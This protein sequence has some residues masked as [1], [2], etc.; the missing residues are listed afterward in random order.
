MPQFRRH[1]RFASWTLILCAACMS[2]WLAACAPGLSEFGTPALDTEA[3]ERALLEASDDDALMDKGRELF[4]AGRYDAAARRFG[5]LH[6]RRPRDLETT[7]RL[8]LA[9]WFA[10]RPGEAE[11][12]WRDFPAT[13]PQLARQLAR[14]AAALRILAH[15]LSA[16]RILEDHRRGELL[17]AEPHGIVLLPD[18]ARTEDERAALPGMPRALHALLLRALDRVAG[19]HPADRGL[20]LALRAEAGHDLF[21]TPDEALDLARVLGTGYAATVRAFVPEEAPDTLRTT[22]TLLPAEPL[23]VRRA[24]L[25]RE[26]RRAEAAWSSAEAE[27]RQL[28]VRRER[29]ANVLSYFNAKHRLNDLLARRK[30][31]A[32]SAARMN[33]EGNAAQA[34]KAMRRHAE[35]SR[36]LAETQT[37]I[38]DYERTMVLGVEG[39]WRF[40]PEAYRELA[41]TLRDRHEALQAQLG[42][43]RSTAW[44]AVARAAVSWPPQGR[45][46][47]F[48]LPLDELGQWPRRAAEELAVLGGEPRPAAAP[49]LDAPLNEFTLL[50]K[51][52]AARDNGEYDR[53]AALFARCGAICPDPPASPG[54]G[55]DVL[56]LSMA[57]PR[58]VAAFFLDDFNLDLETDHD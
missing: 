49:P 9:Q 44:Q 35:T 54:P 20:I 58:E 10:G 4:A 52:W 30:Q 21:A 39:V 28:E 36:E 48:E 50:D 55:F 53:A 14:R 56:R 15:R 33:R 45:S 46:A 42:R 43:L 41:E 5:E 11:T 26:R 40:T 19:L 17:P 2:L 8:G 24:R 51:A 6:G 7:V 25:D 23:A 3:R 18:L 1:T 29:C 47:S 57:A 22:L 13:E 16:R 32:E 31:L 37:E 34:A 27:L 38:R 12:L